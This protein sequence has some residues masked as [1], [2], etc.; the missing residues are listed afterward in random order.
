MRGLT[1]LDIPQQE[2]EWML[3]EVRH[4][5]RGRVLAIHILLLCAVG[6]TPTESA[7]FLFCSRPSG[8]R[9]MTASQPLA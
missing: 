1:I 6:R 9:I 4:A 8:S 2:Q 3:A 5:R 7:T